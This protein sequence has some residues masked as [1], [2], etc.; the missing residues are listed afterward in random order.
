VQS[1]RAC[2]WSFSDARRIKTGGLRT[3]RQRLAVEITELQAQLDEKRAELAEID[4]GAASDP[5]AVTITNFIKN[6]A[7]EER[8]AGRRWDIVFGVL[9][10]AL[11]LLLS[12]AVRLVG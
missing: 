9:F 8:A 6:W 12:N 7:R 5:T 1:A 10:L 11:S 3:T 4:A 2:G